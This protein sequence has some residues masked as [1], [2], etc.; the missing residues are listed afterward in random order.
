MGLLGLGL[1]PAVHTSS[2]V[3]DEGTVEQPVVAPRALPAVAP[4][5]SLPLHTAQSTSTTTK[6]PA[7]AKLTSTRPSPS[8]S[9]M[10]GAPARSAKSGKWRSTN[11]DGFSASVPSSPFKIQM[12][13]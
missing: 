7:P 5:Q 2:P 11:V 13:P 9:A 8:K 4:L 12:A 3:N 6:Q 10:F 1:R